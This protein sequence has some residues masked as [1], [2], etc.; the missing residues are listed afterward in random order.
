MAGEPVRL[1][2]NLKTRASLQ[3][4]WEAFSD[5]DQFARVAGQGF[6]FTEEAQADGSVK[7]TGRMKRMGMSFTWDELPFQ[8]RAPN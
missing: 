3:Q 1:S 7:R 4:T 2:W 5:T 6:D 8:Y